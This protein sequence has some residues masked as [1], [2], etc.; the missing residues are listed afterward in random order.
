MADL[1]ERADLTGRVVLVAGG[2]GAVGEGIV[3]AM[4]G[5]GA[6]VVVPS[7]TADRVAALRTRLGEPAGLHGVVGD[8]GAPD[9]AERV[10]AAALAKG[11]RLDA[12]VAAVGGWWQRSDL[13]D[14][15]PAEWRRVLEASLTTHFLLIRA[16]L[17]RLREQVGSSYQLVVGDTAES[18]VPGASLSTVTAAGVL[19]LFRAA[20]AEERVVRVNALYLAPV[21]TRNRPTGPAGW[22]TAEEVGVY[23]AWLASDAGAAVRGEIVRPDKSGPH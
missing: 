10:A 15:D 20:A 8:V 6:Q 4:L 13:V 22:L 9:G 21:L 16:L 12:V 1:T 2:A 3:A 11:G 14:V 7:R 19:G 18:P 23:A 5:A 17:P